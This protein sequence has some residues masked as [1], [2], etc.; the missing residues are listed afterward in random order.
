M[1]VTQ[2]LGFFFIA[3]IMALILLNMVSIAASL[4]GS[5]SSETDVFEPKWRR[6]FFLTAV[7]AL[8]SNILCWAIVVWMIGASPELG[9]NRIPI[10]IFAFAGI[11]VLS[12]PSLIWAVSLTMRM[13]NDLRREWRANIV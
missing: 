6:R 13:A 4:K 10:L 2:S 11:G 8:L 5:A 1:T 7:P 3:V 12:V 9:D